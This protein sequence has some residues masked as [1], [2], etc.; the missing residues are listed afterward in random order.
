MLQIVSGGEDLAQWPCRN[1]PM[2]G[3]V[4]LIG[5]RL[6]GERSAASR[7]VI[8]K[9][10]DEIEKEVLCS[11]W[12]YCVEPDRGRKDAA[13]VKEQMEVLRPFC[14][15]IMISPE[16]ERGRKDKPRVKPRAAVR[17]P[18]QIGRWPWVSCFL[19]RV[20]S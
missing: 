2:M 7:F 20:F 6:D 13:C 8:D 15:V 16:H 11:I 14:Q 12:A 3:H 19:T 17:R 4:A 1:R 10:T 5:C 18:Q 9:R